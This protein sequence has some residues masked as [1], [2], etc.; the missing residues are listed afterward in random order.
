MFRCV[1]SIHTTAGRY[2]GINHKSF[3][4]IDR[5]WKQL[6]LFALSDP[7]LG[8]HSLRS[9]GSQNHYH[10]LDDFLRLVCIYWI[11][12]LPPLLLIKF[13]FLLFFLSLFMFSGSTVRFTYFTKYK[14]HWGT[15]SKDHFLW[16]SLR[17]C[18]GIPLSSHCLSFPFWLHSQ[19]ERVT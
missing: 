3:L 19:H 10:L 13:L 14:P 6:W 11:M 15:E 17:T 4:K 2:P 1:S 9:R 12:F 5:K 16:T 7:V 18:S 8:K